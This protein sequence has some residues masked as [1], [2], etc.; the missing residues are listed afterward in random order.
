M[1]RGSSGNL[2]LCLY[3]RRKRVVLFSPQVIRVKVE[4][5]DHE[6]QKDKDEDNHELEDVLHS[7]AQRYLQRSKALI[8]WEDVCN[9]RKAQNHC[10]GVQAL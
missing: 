3:S 8:S 6:G 2:I 4:H 1:K 7:S 9:S 10:D 5:S